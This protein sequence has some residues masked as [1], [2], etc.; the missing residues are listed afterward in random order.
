[1][2]SFDRQAENQFRSQLINLGRG[3]LNALFPK[4]IEYFFVALELVDS[5]S[6]TVDYFSFPIL[7][8]EIRE[9]AN[10]ITRVNKTIGG[11]NVLVNSTFNPT[12]IS[13]K[14]TFGKRFKI[15]I[16]QK[17]LEF[18]GFGMSIQNGKFSITSPNFLGKD[19]PQ[20]SSFAKTGY[21][22]I[23]YLQAMKDKSKS[24]NPVDKKPYALYLYNPILGNNYQVEIISFIHS[25]DIG[26]NMVPQYSIQLTS[27][28]DLDQIQLGKGRLKS[29]IKNLSITNIQKNGNQVAQQLSKVLP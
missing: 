8:E 4:E 14:G 10:E 7:P 23:K 19:Y 13:I 5:K 22:C 29:A 21:G 16:N 11:V 24:I 27:V 15:L 2:A 28:A 6:N 26:K 18:A 25:Q 9:T 20:L 17:P 1:M 12:Q 3:T